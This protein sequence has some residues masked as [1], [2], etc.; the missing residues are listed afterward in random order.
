MSLCGGEV[1][2]SGM[3]SQRD[4]SI[5]AARNGMVT[6]FRGNMF[7]LTAAFCGLWSGMGI[8]IGPSMEPCG[9]QQVVNEGD[10]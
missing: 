1:L 3:G 9:S 7:P 5:T 4:L 10:G 2:V 6:V 8:L